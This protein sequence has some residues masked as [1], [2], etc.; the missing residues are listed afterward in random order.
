M[1][2]RVA[3]V[4]GGIQLRRTFAVISGVGSEC[5][6]PLEHDVGYGFSI[7]QGGA[8]RMLT[9]LTAA[10]KPIRKSWR[11]QQTLDSFRVLDDYLSFKRIQ[12]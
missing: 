7:S 4:F 1:E 3:Q 9:R 5:A 12:I 2:C 11:R 8:S 10:A 6:P